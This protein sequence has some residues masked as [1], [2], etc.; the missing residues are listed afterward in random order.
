[1]GVYVMAALFKWREIRNLAVL[2]CLWAGPLLSL[3]LQE[4]GIYTLALFTLSRI[5]G[6]IGQIAP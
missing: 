6:G 4:I 1:M 5:R 3:L 2:A